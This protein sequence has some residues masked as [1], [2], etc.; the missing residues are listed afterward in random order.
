[1]K[2]FADCDLHASALMTIYDKQVKE[3]DDTCKYCSINIF[4]HAK[5]SRIN[6]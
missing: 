4:I 3:A 2:K 6:S 1:M 5:F